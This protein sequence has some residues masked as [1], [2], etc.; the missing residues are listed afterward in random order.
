M[1]GFRIVFLGDM[2]WNDL[3]MIDIEKSSF[4]PLVFITTGEMAPD[5][6]NATES[7]KDWKKK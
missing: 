4:N 2:T 7:T 3:R 5:S 1:V 6:E